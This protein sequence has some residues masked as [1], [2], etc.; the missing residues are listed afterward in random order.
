MANVDYSALGSAEVAAALQAEML[1]MLGNRLD[2]Y[3]DPVFVL[4]RPV[5]NT[6]SAVSKQF[7]SGFDLGVMASVGDGSAMTPSVPSTSS[8]SV[9]VARQGIAA[10]VT[11]LAAGAWHFE[12]TK[13]LVEAV[14]AGF[15]GAARRRFMELVI[16]LANTATNTVGGGAT[17]SATVFD[18]AI[19][20]LEAN[21]ADAN[22]AIYIAPANHIA[23]LR[24]S[25][26]ALSGANQWRMDAQEF[27]G[28]KS[29]AYKGSWKGVQ[30]YQ[31]KSS[32]F[33][34]IGPDTAG[35]FIAKGGIA[36]AEMIVNQ[37][38]Y[39]SEAVENV[40][41]ILVEA[42]RT[43]LSGGTAIAGHYHVGVSIAQQGALVQV[44]ATT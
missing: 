31:G 26:G 36:V 29:G 20:K 2:L 32:Q 10:F 38:L 39:G 28:A 8:V 13:G 12:S 4:G 5:N 9:T 34:V 14:A 22:G 23:S 27:I 35:I 21:D 40:T 15:V 6:G 41:P 19:A 30:V 37:R 42:Q 25:V 33:P 3:G 11:D 16:A 43:P 1:M 7:I 44:L 18:A 17:M 24:T